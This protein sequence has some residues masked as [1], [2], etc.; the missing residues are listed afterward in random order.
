VEPETRYARSGEVSIAYQ[1]TGGGPFDVVN[2]PP[3]VSHVELAWRVPRLAAYYERLGSFSRLI[4][5]DKRG[6]GMSDRVGGTPSLETRMDDV[7]TAA[8]GPR[9]PL[10]TREEDY[11]R[12]VEEDARS[13]GAPGHAVEIATYLHP[14]GTDADR[15]ALAT[16]IRRSAS[17][18]AAA[19]LH[20]MNRQI[21]VRGV[22]PSVHV[23]TLV[24]N[25]RG[26]APNI[27]NGS[28]YLAEHIPGARHVELPG[29]DHA[30]FAGDTDLL[31]GTIE[32]FLRKGGRVRTR[33]GEP[34]PRHRPLHRYRRLDGEGH[35]AGR[36]AVA[37]ARR[38]SPR[39]RTPAASSLPRQG[40]R[41]RR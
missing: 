28:R 35:R 21:D 41:H 24:V 23:P 40:A 6:T 39:A 9:S 37:R 13:W 3:F 32:E 17:P 22:L 29:R 38:S 33:G 1:V 34:R 15:Q 5:F 31:L 14:S 11:D 16:M 27:V 36:C 18:G 7:R 12:D 19:D 25:R 8:V 4:R 10:G 2:V 20:R 30:M 26:D